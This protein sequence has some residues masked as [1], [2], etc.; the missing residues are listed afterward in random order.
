MATVDRW[1]EDT[2]PESPLSMRELIDQGHPAGSMDD[3]VPEGMSVEFPEWD[4][5]P[6]CEICKRGVREGLRVCAGLSPCLAA[7]W[8]REGR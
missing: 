8:E 6:C 7:L 2:S 4:D 5:G 3:F 1:S